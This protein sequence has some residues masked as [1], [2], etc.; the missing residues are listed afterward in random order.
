MRVITS[1]FLEN[2]KRHPSYTREN[3]KKLQKAIDPDAPEE[4]NKKTLKKIPKKKG[5]KNQKEENLLA[6]N[7]SKSPKG[8]LKC[9]AKESTKPA[10][11]N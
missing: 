8:T 3:K 2:K 6:S 5:V 11:S 4:P 1:Y 9:C 7:V 10:N